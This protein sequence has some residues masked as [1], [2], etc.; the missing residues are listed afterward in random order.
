M[1]PP[2]ARGLVEARPA[3]DHFTLQTLAR[4][5]EIRA[6]TPA[7]AALRLLWQACQLPD[8]RKLTPDEHSRLAGQIFR[9]LISEDGVLPEDWLAR[10]IARLDVVD[11]DVDTLSGRIAQIRTWTYA[12]HKQG[13]DARSRALAGDHARGRGPAFGCAARAADAAFHRPAHGAADAALAR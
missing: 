11:G 3:S 10:Q 8:F 12:A 2:P 13:L 7:P 4:D 1:Q 6:L 9:H 5:E